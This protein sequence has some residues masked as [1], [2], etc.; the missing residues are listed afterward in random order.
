MA[1][2]LFLLIFIVSFGA[3]AGWKEGTPLPRT[4]PDARSVVLNNQ[5]YVMNGIASKSFFELYD[6]V[7]DGWRPLTPLPSDIKHFAL[8]AGGGRIYLSGGKGTDNAS[9][10]WIY[11]PDAALWIRRAKLPAPRAGHISAVADGRLFLIGGI[12]E[13]NTID[14]YNITTGI[15]ES[16]NAPMPI[17]VADSSATLWGEEIIVVGGVS[18]DGHDVA[19]VQAFHTK[20][21]RW[22]RLA[23]LPQA[24]SGVGVAVLDDTLHIIGGY[25]QSVQNVLPTHFKLKKGKWQKQTPLPQGIHQMALSA[26]HK[27]G[28]NQLVLIG[29]ALGGGFYAVFTASDRVNIYEPTSR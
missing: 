2:V 28:K 9:D 14:V 6:V 23:D 13:A 10:I 27:D 15:W 24:A 18:P 21:R 8:A 19:A 16:I 29:G 20:T 26:T 12:S 11:A 3:N 1:R 5:I 25:A 7:A 17:A 22:R 4:L